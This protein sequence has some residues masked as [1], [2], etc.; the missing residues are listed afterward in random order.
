MALPVAAA[1][2]GL[3]AAAF[4]AFSG[5]AFDMPQILRLIYMGIASMTTHMLWSLP[6][7]DTPVSPQFHEAC[8]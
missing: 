5:A 3:G 2:V 7:Q 6:W 1:T 8:A 4:F